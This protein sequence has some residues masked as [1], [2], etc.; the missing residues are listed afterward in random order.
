MVVMLA[1]TSHGTFETLKFLQQTRLLTK[2][3]ADQ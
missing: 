3:C 2:A 1:N